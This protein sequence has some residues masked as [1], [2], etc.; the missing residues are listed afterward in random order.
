MVLLN[1]MGHVVHCCFR[2]PNIPLPRV[3]FPPALHRGCQTN[4]LRG[5][6]EQS[7]PLPC[8]EK[9]Q[10]SLISLASWSSSINSL[11][12]KQT[13]ST[14]YVHPCQGFIYTCDHCFNI[15]WHNGDILRVA[16]PSYATLWCFHR[17]CCL[18]LFKVGNCCSP[19]STKCKLHI[20]F[21]ETTSCF[22]TAYKI[23]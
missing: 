2:I 5:W 4:H 9:G 17:N 15:S 11:T 8:E 23:A 14:S 1:W 12:R 10:M 19:S 21:S 6:K 3:A 18:L 22:N 13:T 16:V 20:C 7:H